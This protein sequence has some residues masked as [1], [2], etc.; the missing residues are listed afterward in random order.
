MYFMSRMLI[1]LSKDI[2][3]KLIFTILIFLVFIRISFSLKN[4]AAVYCNALGFR[5]L[6][7]LVD[8]EKVGICLLPNNQEVD[9]WDFLMGKIGINYSYCKKI[10]LEAESVEDSKLCKITSRCTVCIFPNGTKIDVI[11][12]MKLSFE[13]TTC[14]DG[15][16]GFPENHL[17]CP[18]D[19]PSGSFDGVCDKIRDNICDVDCIMLNQ[20]KDDIDCKRKEIVCLN[21]KDGICEEDCPEDPDCKI[22]ITRPPIWIFII[23][24]LAITSILFLIHNKR[25]TVFTNINIGK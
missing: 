22:E 6:T 3:I 23:I 5:Y 24:I 21:I 13:E 4:P 11:E 17:T 10:G 18:Q 25:R 8:E 9:A 12:L 19:C 2:V 1:P 15:I 16:C 20:T 7:K 14:G